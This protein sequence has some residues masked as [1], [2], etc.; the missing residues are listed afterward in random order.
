ML[1]VTRMRAATEAG[2]VVL[3][4]G[5]GD[6]Q[7]SG[8]AAMAAVVAP[9]RACRCREGLGEAPVGLPSH[10]SSCASSRSSA[11]APSGTQLPNDI[12]GDGPLVVEQLYGLA[13]D[14]VLMHP[15]LLHS[16]TTNLRE[17]PRIMINGMVRAVVGGGGPPPPCTVL[18][19]TIDLLN[20]MS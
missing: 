10:P 7:H 8:M 12:E 19:R 18:A 13:G 2:R 16:G 17:R 15:L 14:V 5:C 9:R 6:V 4:C 1:C 3:A 20:E 11:V